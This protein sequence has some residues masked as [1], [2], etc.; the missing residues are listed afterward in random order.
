M[1]AVSMGYDLRV[2]K[3]THLAANR[4]QGVVK[5]GVADRTFPRLCD[6]SGQ[7]GAIFPRIAR[8]DQGFH[9]FVA[10]RRNV[11]RP[12]V[13]IGKPQR[14]ALIHRD[15]AENLSEIFAEADARHDLLGLAEAAPL[16]HASSVGR[17]FLDRLDIS[18]EP[19]QPMDGMLLGLQLVDAKPAVF[20]HPV[21]HGVHCAIHEALDGEMS[22]AGEI[23]ELHRVAFLCGWR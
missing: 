19:C 1:P 6:Q 20:A 5:A 17:H 11:L 7:G 22:Q 12:E 2:G 23:V 21:A 8:G 18:R 3:S 4:L 14:F 16:G 13:E 10:K 15:G 9:V